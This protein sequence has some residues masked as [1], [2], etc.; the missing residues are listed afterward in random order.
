M[1][2]GYGLERHFVYPSFINWGKMMLFL[3]GWLAILLLVASAFDLKSRI[4]PNWLNLLMALTAPLAWWWSGL[5]LWPDVAW[6]IGVALVVFLGFVGLFALGGMGGGDVK[7]IGAVALWTDIHLI[8]PMLLI[9]AVTGGLVAV[10]MLIRRKVSRSPQNPELPY[11]LAITAAGLW[12][13]HQQYINH[14]PPIPLT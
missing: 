13:L 6:Q 10:V 11:G 1:A 14:L 12:V 7:M 8:V 4:I 3:A 9:M 2:S 5:A